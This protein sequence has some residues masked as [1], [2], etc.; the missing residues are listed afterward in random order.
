MPQKQPTKK[1]HYVP[2]TYLKGF[3]PDDNLV[4]QYNLK[5]KKAISN[6]VSIESVCRDNYLYE[7]RD[8][9]DNII[10]L[11]LIE[12]ILCGYEGIFAEYKRKLLSK[13]SHKEN[14]NTCSFLSK[15]EKDFWS[16]Y[17]TL[18]I[19]R[20]P[21]T[22]QGVKNLLYE[23]YPDALSENAA[24]NLA[25]SYCLPFIKNAENRD[26]NALTFFLSVLLTSIITVGVTDSD[27]LFSSDHAIYGSR[28]SAKQTIPEFE[29]IWFPISSNCAL[30]FSNPKTVDRTM[31]NRLIS[32][33]DEEVRNQNKGIAYIAS[34]MVFSKHPFSNDEIKLIEEAR[35]ERAQDEQRKKDL[36]S[37]TQITR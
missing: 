31:R 26:Y 6:P 16:L 37:N 19:M 24:Y 11:N 25:L 1:Q 22:I 33:Q 3:S 30:I 9:E 17:T 2:I 21:V 15:D 13:V 36:Y 4:Y 28:N 35:N 18:H 8:N 7:F 12:D 20:N 10:N 34:N 27:N 14:F 23:E 5:L 29:S 32:L